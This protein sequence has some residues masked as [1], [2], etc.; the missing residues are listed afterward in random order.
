MR[1]KAL[2]VCRRAE[3]RHFQF[4]SHKYFLFSYR[5]KYYIAVTHFGT[6]SSHM[7]FRT[8]FALLPV[9]LTAFGPMEGAAPEGKPL[10]PAFSPEARTPPR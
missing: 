7:G 2:S 3:F 8:I 10:Q 5:H 9:L 6:E 4:F 1:K